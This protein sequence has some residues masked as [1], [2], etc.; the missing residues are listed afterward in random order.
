MPDGSAT[1]DRIVPSA[2]RLA[3]A[4][5]VELELLTVR[6]ASGWPPIDLVR[7]RHGEDALAQ[8]DA[9]DAAHV[10]RLAQMAADE[11]VRASWRLLTDD[12]PAI[13]ITDHVEHR[14]G[15]LLAM[16][17]RGRQGAGGRWRLGEIVRRVVRTSRAPIL[18][19][20][21]SISDQRPLDEGRSTST[22]QP[23]RRGQVRR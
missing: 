4:L 15:S 10:R 23:G 7:P 17:T 19:A 12:D 9:A 22:L 6:P 2:V 20:G 14:S 13:A 1:S 18:L 11:Q 3:R 5:R 21:P 16:H 8:L